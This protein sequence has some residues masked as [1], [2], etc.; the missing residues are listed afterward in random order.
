MAY[1]LRIEDL[2]VLSTALTQF[3]ENAAIEDDDALVSAEPVDAPEIARARALLAQIDEA[4]LNAQTAYA[5]RPGKN[6]PI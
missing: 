6:Q 3:I 2:K 4:W 1:S 5:P